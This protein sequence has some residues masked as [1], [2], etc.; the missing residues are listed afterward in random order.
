MATAVDED[1]VG[2]APNFQS[3][4]E[5]IKLCEEAILKAS[6]A[7]PFI[8]DNFD[9]VFCDEIFWAEHLGIFKRSQLPIEN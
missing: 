4:I 1:E 6:Y 9:G 3:N 5:W 2:F 8:L 7:D